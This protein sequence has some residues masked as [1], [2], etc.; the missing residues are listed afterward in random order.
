MSIEITVYKALLHISLNSQNSPLKYLC[1]FERWENRFWKTESWPK[2]CVWR[3]GGLGNKSPQVM[4]FPEVASLDPCNNSRPAL[5]DWGVQIFLEEKRW[6]VAQGYYI[7]QKSS[8]KQL[9][10]HPRYRWEQGLK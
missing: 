4:W 9:V 10:D 5:V 2:Q 8:L 7:R 6:T 3:V 1:S